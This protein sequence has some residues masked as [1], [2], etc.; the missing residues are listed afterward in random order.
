MHPE[1]TRELTQV[2]R[3][4]GAAKDRR[5]AACVNSAPKGAVYLT[6]Q[7]PPPLSSVGPKPRFDAVFDAGFDA[8]LPHP[9]PC[10]GREVGL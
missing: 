5:G 3:K 2:W 9:A 8:P 6:Q 1:L 7:S 4:T 10:V